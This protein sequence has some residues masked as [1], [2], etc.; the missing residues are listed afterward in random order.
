VP[1]LP[2]KSPIMFG[3][4]D[5]GPETAPKSPAKASAKERLLPGGLP[6][7]AR[8][9]PAPSGR[10]LPQAGRPLPGRRAGAEPAGICRAGSLPHSG[11]PEPP[12][13]LRP[14]FFPARPSPGRRPRCSRAWPAPKTC[15][16]SGARQHHGR[17]P[18]RPASSC[19]G[20]IQRRRSG[21]VLFAL[22]RRRRFNRH[23][24][25]LLGGLRFERSHHPAGM[26]RGAAAAR[27]RAEDS[28]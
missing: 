22:G 1:P 24:L 5:I 27:T 10:V 26:Q 9:E 21:H 15:L 3:A 14:F 18:D 20:I 12:Q 28:L 11:S 7:P 13:L 6:A 2:K 25:L 4:A 23:F 19:P 17:D 16:P 8:R